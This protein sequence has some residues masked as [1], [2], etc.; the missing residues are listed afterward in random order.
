MYIYIYIYIQ[1]RQINKKVLDPGA[2]LPRSPLAPREDRV[3]LAG[4]RPALSNEFS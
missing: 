4:A 3:V 1:R 2:D